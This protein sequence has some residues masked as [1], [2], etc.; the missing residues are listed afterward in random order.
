MK[1][2]AGMP[3]EHQKSTRNKTAQFCH[4]STKNKEETHN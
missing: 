2:T 3:I 4:N 1:T